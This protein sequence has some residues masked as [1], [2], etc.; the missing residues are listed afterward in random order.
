MKHK[1][2]FVNIIGNPNVGKSTLMNELIGENISIITN[3]VQ[4]TR[5]RIL[6]ILNSEEYQIIFSDTPGIIDPKYKLQE[7]MMKAV[8]S[9]FE[10]SDILI[11]M[12][13]AE[14]KKIDDTILAKVVKESIPLI[15]LI[16]KIDLMKQEEVEKEILHWSKKMPDAYILPIS[17]LNKFN[18]ENI[19]NHIIQVLPESEPYYPKDTLTDKSERFFVQEKIR[20]KIL[21]HYKKE[22]PYSVE[23][24]VEEFINEDNIIRIR[25]IIYVLRESQKRIIIGHQGQGIK[26]IGSEARKDLEKF[27]NKKIFLQTPVKVKK[28]W[29]NNK[30][31]LKDFGY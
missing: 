2:G 5:H 30:S 24:K 16:N 27:L 12:T 11:Y 28:N 13:C 10:D 17:A 23:V 29:R 7:N 8:Y 18:I 21:K 6:G 3:K 1:S 9:V 19:I 25:A 26:R 31:Q 14:D 20:E 22:I 15:I 4:T